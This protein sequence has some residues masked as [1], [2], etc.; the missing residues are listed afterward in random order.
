MAADTPLRLLVLEDTEAD[1][2]LIQRRLEQSGLKARIRRVDRTEQLAAALADEQ[3]DAVLYDYT[4][5]GMHFEDTIGLIR[6]Q[7]PELP[8]VLVS[9][10]VSEEMAV[11][12]LQHGLNDFVLKDNLLRLPS[13]IR[14]AVNSAA[15][16]CRRKRAEDQLRK[17]AM[18]VEQSPTSI[19]IT[20]TRPAI[21]YVN[22]AF[23]DQTGYSAAEVLGQNPSILNQGKTPPATYRN[24]WATI[25]RGEVWN[26]EFCNTRKDGSVYLE[27]ATVAPIRAD[28]GRVTHYVAV[29]SDVT[30]LRDSESRIHQLANFDELTG[31]PNRSL[32]L[33]RL[34][35]ASRSARQTGRHGMVLA[36]DLDGFKFINDTHG[37]DIGN[38]VLESVAERLRE[39]LSDDSTV[40]RI[41][42]N[43]F[44]VVVENLSRRRNRAATQAH[45]LAELIHEELQLPHC[46]GE[47]ETLVRHS[48]TM[49][50]CLVLHDH[51]NAERL[52][53]KAE[54][55]LQRARDAGRN[56]W[57]FFN[58]EMQALVEARGR[59][60]NGLHQ[61]L[62]QNHLALAYQS[63][64]DASGR[65]I[66]AEGLIR[67]NR[68]GEDPIP[69]GQFI[70]L[71][72]ETGLILPIGQ[73]VL[74]TACRQ[75]QSWA[76]HPRTRGLHL[77]INVSA[78]QFH[79]PRFV[80]QLLEALE[81]YEIQP[82]RLSLEL[83]E[84]VVLN[85]LHQTQQRMLAI[86]DLGVGLALDDF[87]TGFS[88][89]SYLKNLP[90]HTLKIDRSFVS[91]MIATTSSAAIVRATISMGHALGLTVIA[92]GV[93][94]R[95]ELDLLKDFGCNA[96][97]GFLFARPVPGDQWQ[98]EDQTIATS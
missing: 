29:K 85:D 32:L 92:E 93:E 56:S 17:L 97:Q 94:T 7:R 76:Q 59:I 47:T 80:D 78:R 74:D 27:T 69:P 24:L 9:G 67:W 40:A 50:L 8:I 3:W 44:A 88:S 14:R 90:F 34:Q 57:C 20:D 10:T 23:L 82:G 41:G 42:G 28:D 73:W 70:P 38:R 43:R 72:E 16:R 52:L 75:L 98:P 79:E 62:E 54:I 36:L 86:R 66:G 48:T 2:L 39:N 30:Q 60:E 96:F 84:S 46:V 25:C 33:D 45:D 53:N 12:L 18:V 87:G 91:D 11:T 26:G 35:Q 71:A 55:A 6:K 63:Q 64:F 21:E 49:G 83:T 5:P 58:G 22:Q 37:Y 61:A 15:E 77:S 81:R 51:E 31:L 1:A 13:V 4:L 19:V 68:P 65:L 95:A 89:L